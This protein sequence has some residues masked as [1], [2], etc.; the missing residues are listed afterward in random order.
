MLHRLEQQ[1]Q[2]L[3]AAAKAQQES[4]QAQQRL[5]FDAFDGLEE[6][7]PPSL[8]GSPSENS[9]PTSTLKRPEPRQI[10]GY[11]QALPSPGPGSHIINGLSPEDDEADQNVNEPKD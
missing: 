7:Q 5:Y 8:R 11:I 9:A 6:L 3:R 2:S 4:S 1:S 10:P